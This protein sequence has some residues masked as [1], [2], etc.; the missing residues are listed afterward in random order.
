MLLRDTSA[1]GES[2]GGA[3]E[4]LGNQNKFGDK[5]QILEG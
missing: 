4:N 2:I 3:E 5:S 1:L